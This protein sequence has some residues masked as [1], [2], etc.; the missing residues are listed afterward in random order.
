VHTLVPRLVDIE[1]QSG[2][3]DQGGGCPLPRC[4]PVFPLA[5]RNRG[6][7]LH[8]R[9][10]TGAHDG[11][12]PARDDDGP[13]DRLAGLNGATLVDDGMA[14]DLQRGEVRNW[15]LCIVASVKRWREQQQFSPLTTLKDPGLTFSLLGVLC[16]YTVHVQSGCFDGRRLWLEEQ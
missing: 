9:P 6:F 8:A 10:L 11:G 14:I 13:R 7:H 12:K 16:T 3:Q 4:N 1:R 2:A 15:A 5:I